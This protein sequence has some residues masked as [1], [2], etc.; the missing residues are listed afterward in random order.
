MN[1]KFTRKQI[2]KSL[3]FNFIFPNLIA[4]V[5]SCAFFIF[6]AYTTINVNFISKNPSMFIYISSLVPILLAFLFFKQFINA[7]LDIFFS[8]A[9]K[10]SCKV[11]F[12][13]FV[14]AEKHGNM[15]PCVFKDLKRKRG[16]CF[17]AKD[18]S[19]MLKHKAVNIS[20][21]GLK[22]TRQIIQLKSIDNTPITTQSKNIEI[23]YTKRYFTLRYALAF[24]EPI[25][26]LWLIHFIWEK[27]L[28]ISN[29]IIAFSFLAYIIF[30]Y[31][32]AY[33][34]YKTFGLEVGKSPIRFFLSFRRLCFTFSLG[35]EIPDD[36]I[37]RIGER[38]AKKS[39]YRIVP[40]VLIVIINIF[41]FLFCW[42]E[43]KKLL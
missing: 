21:Y 35:A 40:M 15:I 13:I 39:F 22:R 31:I 9:E 4:P 38:E 36:I 2:F 28:D 20:Y 5:I 41:F 25:I 10:Y 33:V 43:I 14:S 7:I 30:V 12:P 42:L 8:K 34:G 11:E 27:N 18:M 26:F 1:P 23:K 6:I 29:F 32:R 3:P 37:Q 17:S 16:V 24:F 19:L